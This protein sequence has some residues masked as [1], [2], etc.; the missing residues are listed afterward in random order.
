MHPGGLPA[1]RPKAQ[2]ALAAGPKPGAPQGTA[3]RPTLRPF[4]PKGWPISAPRQPSYATPLADRESGPILSNRGLG[5][6]EGAIPT[7][8][9]RNFSKRT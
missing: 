4:P 2:I 1:N 3:G 8:I 9:L 6:S 5:G 7:G